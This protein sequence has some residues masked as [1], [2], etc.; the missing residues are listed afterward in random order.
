[1]TN[2]LRLGLGLALV[3]LILWLRGTDDL[4]TALRTIG[5]QAVVAVS[6][7]HVMPVSFCGL[8]WRVLLVDGPPV[9]TRAFL[10]ARWLRDAINQLLPF[11]PL[12]GEVLGARWLTSRGIPGAA[13]L[14]VVDVTAE[15]MSQVAFSL[16]GVAIWIGRDSGGNILGWAGV[17]VGLSLPMLLGLLLAQHLGLVRLMEKLGDK[18]MPEAWRSPDQTRS[19]HDTMVAIYAERRRFAWAVTLHLGG[20]LIATLQAWTV[21]HLTG[22][23]LPWP[24]VVALESVIYAVRNAAF[25]IPGALGVQEGAYVLVGA[26]LGLPSEAALAVSLIKRGREITVGLPGLVVWQ[27]KGRKAPSPTATPTT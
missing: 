27:W 8:A 26:A 4:L 20:W 13:A 11:M 15:V 9:A 1:M 22:H 2:F 19:I 16:I 5:W 3:A 14:T 10:F 12:G 21:L 18:V 23:P 25:L 17:G 6:L 24:E 7:L